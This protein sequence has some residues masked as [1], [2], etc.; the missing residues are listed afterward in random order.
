MIEICERIAEEIGDVTFSPYK[1]IVFNATALKKLEY[2]E[3]ILF[4]EKLGE[5]HEKLI[6]KEKEL[7]NDRCIKVLGGIVC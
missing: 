7:A 3:G 5:T 1:Q 2:Y 4:I 6:K